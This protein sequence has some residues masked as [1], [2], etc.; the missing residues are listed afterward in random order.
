R[1]GNHAAPS[2]VRACSQAQLCAPARDLGIDEINSRRIRVTLRDGPLARGGR[3]AQTSPLTRKRHSTLSAILA[4]MAEAVRIPISPDARLPTRRTLDE[5]L[6]VRW[7]G[8]YAAFTR[9]VLL[10]PPR[11]RLRRALL[12]RGVLSGWASWARGDLDL[13]VVPF[14][15]DCHTDTLPSLL[16]VGMRSSY[17]GH[18]GRRELAADV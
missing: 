10:L 1:R 8:A 3:A 12:R 6:F 7:P 11:S 2:G 17:E 18:A 15:P 9:A 14:A 5:R 16:A 13:N 4:S